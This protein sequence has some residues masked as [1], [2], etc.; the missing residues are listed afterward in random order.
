LIYHIPYF[1]DRQAVPIPHCTLAISW[2]RDR[3][4]S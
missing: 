2:Q 4:R 1:V 3:K